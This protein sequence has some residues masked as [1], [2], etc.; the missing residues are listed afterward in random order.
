MP[1]PGP[2]R[3]HPHAPRYFCDP[4]GRGVFLCG[5]HHWDSVQD[6]GERPG[7]FDFD[8]YLDR[9]GEWG[10]SFVRLWAHE[11]W[12]R[13]VTPALWARSGPGLARDGLPRFDLA[14]VN[15]EFLERLRQ[16]AI[17]AGERGLYVSVMLFNGWA[18]RDNGEGDPWPRHPFHRDNNVNGIDGDPGG[19]GDGAAVH[20]LAIPAITRLQ[21]AYVARLVE[22]VG[23]LPHLLWEIANES[24]AS[25]HAWQVHLVEHLR[26]LEARR[27]LQHPVG[28]TFAYPG[29]GNQALFQ[30]PADWISPGRRGGWMKHPPAA[31]GGK[32]VLVDT[33]HL[34]GVGGDPLWVWKTVLRGHQPLYM[35]PLDEDPKHQASRRAMGAARRLADRLDIARFDVAPRRGASGFALAAGDGTVLALVERSRLLAR[36]GWVGVARRGSWSLEWLDLE[37]GEPFRVER[38]CAERGRL[39][40]ARP[41]GRDALLLL[42][43]LTQ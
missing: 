28:M 43:P 30:G 38:V 33:D 16:R 35:D 19:G 29:G 9:L 26:R 8:R 41:S 5:S 11:A 13:A 7:G 36:S 21:E 25:S 10:H 14:R 1:P 32:V 17:A 37:R 18:I 27:P 6:N 23:D 3:R 31:D 39:S 2:L 22:A 20:S 24:P 4:A 12:I 34:W 40:L 15:P 42:R